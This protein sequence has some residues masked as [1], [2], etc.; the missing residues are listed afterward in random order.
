VSA[1]ELEVGDVVDF[2]GTGDFAKITDINLD[3]DFVNIVFTDIES[4]EENLPY[5]A[6][7]D[8]IVRYYPKSENRDLY[9]SRRLNVWY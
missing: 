7:D 6:F 1:I 2:E 3:D 8:Q 9:E 5:F 4:G